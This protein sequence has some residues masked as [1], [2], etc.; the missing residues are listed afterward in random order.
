MKSDYKSKL[1]QDFEKKWVEFETNNPLNDSYEEILRIKK[2]VDMKSKKIEFKRKTNE[3]KKREAIKIDGLEHLVD[4][5]EMTADD[6]KEDYTDNYWYYKNFIIEANEYKLN[7]GSET[8]GERKKD[9]MIFFDDNHHWFTKKLKKEDLFNDLA[10]TCE[11]IGLDR[12]MN[13]NLLVFLINVIDDE[14]LYES[15]KDSNIFADDKALR[16]LIDDKEDE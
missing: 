4:N 2:F 12:S 9:R 7:F 16:K 6:I 14:Y 8:N 13:K 1:L 3:I 15:V 5:I 10:D 11:K